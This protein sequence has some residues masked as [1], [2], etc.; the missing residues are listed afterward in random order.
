MTDMQVRQQAMSA[1]Q[2][3]ATALAEV[4][5]P[6]KV[7]D[8]TQR[9][10]ASGRWQTAGKTPTATIHAQLAMDI[11]KH[12]AQSRFQR[13]GKARFA[14]RAWGLP[15]YNVVPR[16]SPRASEPAPATTPTQIENQPPVPPTTLSFTN[17]AERV[18]ERFAHR[19]PMHYREMTRLALEHGLL[20]TV[21]QTPEATL[22]AQII[23]ENARRE[24]RGETPRFD[25][26][27]RGF[28][29]LTKWHGNG[30]AGQ[31]Q[32]HN[33]EVRHK[34]L[35]RLKAMPPGEFEALIAQLLTALGFEEVDVTSLSGDG[36][37]DVRGTLVVGD[38]IRTR[39]A[40][41]VKRWRNNIQA[42]TV[43]QVRGALGTHEQGLIITTSDFSSGARAEAE[44]P[45]AV[46]VGLMNGE[47]LVALLVEHSVGIRRSSHDLIEL[48]AGD[49]ETE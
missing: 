28:V 25:R 1:L 17:A 26:M 43:Q 18:L 33:T 49:N 14:L 32:Q 41:Q 15:E 12:G 24:R 6:L 29:G 39:M 42:P 47:Q 44:R 21:G 45:N 2:A 23:T 30:L 3:A 22:Y 10:L 48:D 46:P 11:K 34:L 8:L 7:E 9:V 4:G 16:S 19:Q 20:H 37:I 36:G 13:V 27:P 31:I 5:T 40:V 35:A 38:V